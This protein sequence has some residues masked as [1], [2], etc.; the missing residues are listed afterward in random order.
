MSRGVLCA[1]RYSCIGCVIF[2]F[3]QN[4]TFYCVCTVQFYQIGIKS[5]QRIT[6]ICCRTRVTFTNKRICH[7]S[8][9]TK[10]N[11]ANSGAQGRFR[12]CSTRL[13]C[14]NCTFVSRN[15]LSNSCCYRSLPFTGYFINTIFCGCQNL[16]INLTICIKIIVQLVNSRINSN[17]IIVTG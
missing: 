8:F 14:R 3:F 6:N 13:F 2:N 16:C 4:R 12:P 15:R 17:F 7:S 5:N 1:S 9:I 11:I 10:V